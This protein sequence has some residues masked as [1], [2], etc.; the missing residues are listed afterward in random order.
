MI[1]FLISTRLV[2]KP[3]PSTFAVHIHGFAVRPS[4]ITDFIDY[5]FKLEH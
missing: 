3:P 5:C 1:V 4:P 2:F